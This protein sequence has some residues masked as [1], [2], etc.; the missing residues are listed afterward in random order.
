MI[1]QFIQQV[2]D[3]V[4]VFPPAGIYAFFFLIAYLEN[5]IPPIP[6][7]ILVA[8]GGYLAASSVVSVIP[9]V[10]ITTLASVIGF[11]NMYWFGGK[12]A[13]VIEKKEKTHWLLR[14]FDYKYFENG[15]GWMDRWG[16]GVIFANRF[17]AGTRSVISL[18]AG[19]YKLSPKLTILNS[20][21]SS[22]IWNSILVYLGW[23]VKENWQIIGSYLSAYSQI[24]ISVLLLAI[25]ARIGWFF[26]QQKKSKTNI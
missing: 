23:L 9:L 22:I 17:L 24:I 14:F 3:W 19:F 7:D 26:Y 18:M 15:K 6:G 25:L 8:F 2:V 5:I 1:D 20:A 13:D 16:Q 12:W 21:L 11:M 4:S 10:F